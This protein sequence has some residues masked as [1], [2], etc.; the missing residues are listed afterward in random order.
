MCT[1]SN[2]QI[3]LEILDFTNVLALQASK[4]SLS[5][6]LTSGEPSLLSFIKYDDL[7]TILKQSHQTL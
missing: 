3:L 4:T 2:A 6:L 7:C 1:Q 5:N